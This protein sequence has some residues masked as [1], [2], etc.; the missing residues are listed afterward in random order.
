MVTQRE[1]GNVQQIISIESTQINPA[2]HFPIPDSSSP[3]DDDC[4]ALLLTTLSLSILLSAVRLGS[5]INLEFF[6][7]FFVVFN[8]NKYNQTESICKTDCSQ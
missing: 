8:N 3:P 5:S 4:A 6:N 2:T 1:N 7:E